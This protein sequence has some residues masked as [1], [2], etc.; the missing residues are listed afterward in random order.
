MTSQ[1]REE[2][3]KR[4][5]QLDR[6]KIDCIRSNHFQLASSFSYQNLFFFCFQINFKLFVKK[7]DDQTSWPAIDTLKEIENSSIFSL[8][9][10]QLI[11]WTFSSFTS[12]CFSFL[13]KNK[14]KLSIVW[15]RHY[16]RTV[17]TL[18]LISS[19]TKFNFQKHS[20]HNHLQLNYSKV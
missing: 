20:L 8:L 16:R 14:N 4:K 6:F 13:Q 10:T 17:N 7:F 9:T 18:S 11:L 1:K 3:W 19:K 5:K 12:G 2:Q 15:L